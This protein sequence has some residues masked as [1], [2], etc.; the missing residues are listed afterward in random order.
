MEEQ[1]SGDMICCIPEFDVW[2]I[3][4]ARVLSRGG[5]ESEKSGITKY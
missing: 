3:F 4:N 1:D 2:I 5:G